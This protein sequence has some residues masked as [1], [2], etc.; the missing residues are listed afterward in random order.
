[1][2]TDNIGKGFL[3]FNRTPDS[4]KLLMDFNSDK[5]EADLFESLADEQIQHNGIPVVYLPRTFVNV[6]EIM[7]EDRYS[8]FEGRKSFKLRAYM[9]TVEGYE[10]QGEIFMETGISIDDETQLKVAKARF[11]HEAFLQSGE[12]DLEPKEGDLVYIKELNNDI[13]EI[14]AVERE[15]A[16][17]YERGRAV[18]YE[19]KCMK[20][21]PAGEDFDTDDEYLDQIPELDTT[22]EHADHK[23]IK[24]K[25][26][27]NP[28][29]PILD[30]EED[31]FF[32]EY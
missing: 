12:E 31:S 26:T 21:S 20:Y 6:D 11:K 14:F 24:E 3:K 17:F 1:M 27:E 9:T 32:G 25:H 16:N 10:G 13:F 8:L 15:K 30:D 5:Q 22:N 2:G 23:V 18:L 19:F 28:D 4:E 7:G 29:N